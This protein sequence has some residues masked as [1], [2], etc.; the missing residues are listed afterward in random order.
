M[1]KTEKQVSKK[2]FPY[3]RKIEGDQPVAPKKIMCHCGNMM[4]ANKTKKYQEKD[5]YYFA[6][7][8]KCELFYDMRLYQKIP[9]LIDGG[10]LAVILDPEF[11]DCGFIVPGTGSDNTIYLSDAE[12]KKYEEYIELKKSQQQNNKKEK[13]KKNL[14][15]S[16]ET[17]DFIFGE[18]SQ[19]SSFA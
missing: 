4:F 9:K 17:F 16:K 8:D 14:K 6:N 2:P 13:L 10:K 11:V 1:G 5:N 12:V 15:T 19:Q 18:T 7:C 3:A